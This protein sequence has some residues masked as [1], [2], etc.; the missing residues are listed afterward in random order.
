M[1]EL[2]S[3]I[4]AVTDEESRMKTEADSLTGTLRQLEAAI[5]SAKGSSKTL[6]EK[7][8]ASKKTLSLLPEAA[9]NIAELQSMCTDRCVCK[10][11]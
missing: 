8:L 4:A 10:L 6:E 1:E 9:K 5:A 7:I 3:K 2:R 11:P